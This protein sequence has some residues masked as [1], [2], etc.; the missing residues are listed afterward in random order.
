[1]EVH[2][3]PDHEIRVGVET[4]HEFVTVILEVT[5]DFEFL[6]D[7]L[8]RV[9]ATHDLATETFGEHVVTSERH[10]SHHAR[11]RQALVRT[12]ARR[13]VVVIPTPPFRIGHD[14]ATADGAPGDLLRRRLRTRG[15]GRDRCDTV[16]IGGDPL[17][18]LHSTHRS[19][20]DRMPTTD[21]EMIGQTNLCS[22]HV[23]NGDHR[24][25]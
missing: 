2:R 15:D 19:A 7:R 6:V 13:G 18:N 25:S 11:G 14:R 10:L 9:V 8:E 21:S 12:V 24:E 3:L 23:A 16:G 1:M 22:H 17:E 5:L 4:A 20:D